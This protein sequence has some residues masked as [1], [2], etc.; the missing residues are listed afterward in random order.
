MGNMVITTER[1]DTA[2]VVELLEAHLAFAREVSPSE[3]VHALDL[4]G[5]LTPAITFW[6]ARIDGVLAGVGALKELLPHHGEVKSMHTAAAM[7]GKGVA[8]QL[9][10]T[11]IDEA[12]ARSYRSLSLET[13]STDAFAPARRLY[14]TLG[15]VT[16]GPFG[17]YPE[18][19]HSA[20]MQ[21]DLA[22]S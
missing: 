10:T 20:F 14:T 5:L 16:C 9:A 12:V 13:G 17:D 8:R 3:A 4:E 6:T 7:R 21:L 19:P 2:D 22:T 15:F 1:P 18:H 11:V